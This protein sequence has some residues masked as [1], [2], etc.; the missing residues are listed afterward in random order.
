MN[1]LINASVWIQAP[2]VVAVLL[3]FA[4]AAS[5]ALGSLFWLVFPPGSEERYV[6]GFEDG[7]APEPGSGT[8]QLGAVEER[9][10]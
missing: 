9:L 8:G 4:V 10:G 5:K 6:L 7:A 3:L 1:W 2:V